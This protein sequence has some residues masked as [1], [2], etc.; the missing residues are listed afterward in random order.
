MYARTRYLLWSHIVARVVWINRVSCQS[1][2]WPSKQEKIIFPCTR[3]A[4][5]SR[6]GLLVS[7]LSLNLVLAYGI[8]FEFRC[9][10]HLFIYNRHT[11]SC[12]SRVY[13]VAL[14][15]TDGVHCR[16]CTGT[17]PVKIEKLRTSAAFAG[18]HGPIN[19]RLSFQQT[20]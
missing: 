3:S 2:T 15:R 17:G 20:L 10:V 7:I 18:Q 11:P 19:I 8:P 5:P 6:I 9:G 13:M 4:V 1:R 16:V 12:Q 14:M